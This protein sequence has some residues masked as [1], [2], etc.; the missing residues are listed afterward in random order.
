MRPM[1]STQ[2][3]FSLITIVNHLTCYCFF[4]FQ[5][6][7][8]GSCRVVIYAYLWNLAIKESRRFVNYLIVVI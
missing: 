7:V 4:S 3:L 5:F 8:Y 2:Y 6:N 1:P